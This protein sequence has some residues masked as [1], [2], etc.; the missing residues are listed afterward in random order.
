LDKQAFFFCVSR[1]KGR[2]ASQLAF[3]PPEKQAFGAFFAAE[4]LFFTSSG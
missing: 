2:F 1:A 3:C 4:S